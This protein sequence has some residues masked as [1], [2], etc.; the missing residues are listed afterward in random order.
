MFGVKVVSR[1]ASKVLQLHQCVAVLKTTLNDTPLT[2]G[3]YDL[4]VDKLA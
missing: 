3:F 2:I 1:D 4:P